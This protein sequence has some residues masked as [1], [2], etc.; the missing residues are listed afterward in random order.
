MSPCQSCGACCASYR[1][2]FSRCEVDDLPGGQVPEALIEAITPN[3]ACMRGTGSV[4][5]RCTALRGRIGEAVSC[6]IYEFRPS[7]CREFAPLAAVG[8]G[9]EACDEAR[10]C[11]GLAPLLPAAA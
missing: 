2:S 1:V 5:L 9:D 4:P 10:R 7:A 8:R 6:A 3:L 11:H